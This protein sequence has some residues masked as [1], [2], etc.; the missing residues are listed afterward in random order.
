MRRGAASLLRVTGFEGEGIRLFHQAHL[1][2]LEGIVAKP[3]SR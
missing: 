3:G 1:L 2:E